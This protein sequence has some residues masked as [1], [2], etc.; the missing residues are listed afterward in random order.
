MRAFLLFLLCIVSS[1][2]LALDAKQTP[3][4]CCIACARCACNRN[5]LC[6]ADSKLYVLGTG[7]FWATYYVP[8]KPTTLAEVVAGTVRWAVPHRKPVWIAIPADKGRE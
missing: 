6:P 4:P 7:D 5:C 3:Q 2:A 1:P 8:V